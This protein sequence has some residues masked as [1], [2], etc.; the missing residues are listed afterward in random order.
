MDYDSRL[1]RRLPCALAAMACSM[2]FPDQCFLLVERPWRD[3]AGNRV[4]EVGMTQSGAARHER[5]CRRI[6]TVTH[7]RPLC[8]LTGLPYKPIGAEA[9][10]LEGSVRRHSPL[11]GWFKR[12][13]LPVERAES[14]AEPLKSD[15]D[16]EERWLLDRDI[17]QPHPFNS[18][19]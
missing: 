9:A 18:L 13:P 1:R 8:R 5:G 15:L 7:L 10:P 2:S 16:P 4:Y 3:A 17:L 19:T 14:P 11:K 12:R 6:Q